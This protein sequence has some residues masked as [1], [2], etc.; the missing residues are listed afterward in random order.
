MDVNL[1]NGRFGLILK[2]LSSKMLAGS[3]CNDY[4]HTLYCIELSLFVIVKL[5]Q[6][7]LNKLDRFAW[8]HVFHALHQWHFLTFS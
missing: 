4:L 7:G 8:S 3:D 6:Q 5:K 2:L 1:Y